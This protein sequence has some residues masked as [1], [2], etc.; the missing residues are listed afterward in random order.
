ML[1]RAS[2][3][4]SRRLLQSP[5]Q[6]RFFGD[7]NMDAEE[8]AGTYLFFN[9]QIILFLLSCNLL[10]RGKTWRNISLVALIPSAAVFFYVQFFEHEEEGMNLFF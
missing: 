7:M 5:T 6:R 1:G 3:I 10:V 2:S 4:V 8:A 9:I